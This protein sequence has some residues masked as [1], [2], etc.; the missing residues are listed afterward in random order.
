[1]GSAVELVLVGGDPSLLTEGRAQIDELEQRWSRFLPDSDITRINLA[2]GRPLPVDASTIKLIEAMT[3]GW[4]ATGGAFDPTMLAPLVELGYGPSRHEPTIVTRLPFDAVDRADPRAIVIDR[5]A[6]T[7]LAPAGVCLD[8]GGI[9]KGLAADMVAARLVAS[10]ADG[11]LVS[12]GGD[13]AV[14]GDAPRAGGWLVDVG[15]DKVCVRRGGVATSGSTRRTW[16]DRGRRVHH[17]L[18]PSTRESAR[19]VLEASVIAGDAR[20]AEVWT[21]ALSVRGATLLPHLG[22]IGLGG[23]VVRVDGS[24]VTNETWRTFAGREARSAA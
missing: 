23:R 10:G 16:T 8:P 21:K 18:D 20:W 17:L 9:G 2:G 7:V 4:I 14:L 12:L 1:M 15:D 24:V 11:A 3:A 19:G 6:G 5:E 13:I 22:E